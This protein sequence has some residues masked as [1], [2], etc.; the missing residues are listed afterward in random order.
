M[1]KIK[2]LVITSLATVSLVFSASIC[3]TAAQIDSLSIVDNTI[4]AQVSAEN[5]RL[6]AVEDSDGLLSDVFFKDI[7]PGSDVELPVG[8]ASV[9][10]LYLWDRESLAPISVSYVLRDGV[11]YPEGSE[12]PV[13]AYDFS[14]YSFNQDDSVMVVSAV[15]ETEI[16]GFMSGV[17]TTYSLTDNIAVLGISDN[18]ADVVPGSVVLI[19]TNKKGDCA[20]IELLASLG[21]PI[22]EKA[23][24][25]DFG[26]Y[27]PSDGSSRYKNVVNVV[28]SKSNTKLTLG[29]AGNKT[30]YC[31]ESSDVK[32]YRVGLAMM[33]DQL[34]VS[35]AEKL[36]SGK[37][38]ESPIKSTSGFNN[39]VYLRV[40]TEQSKTVSGVTY[41]GLITQC[42]VFS[43]PKE[44]NF[45]PDD[46][47]DGKYSPI[48]GLEPIV[49]ID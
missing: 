3:A 24:R 16:K 49:I 44:L 43:V 10:S 37:A 6:Y 22:D 32:C 4:Y 30:S 34:I 11:A 26:V 18:I 41:D 5:A 40:D 23:F 13:P 31:F 2:K 19:G 45:N 33:N 9:Y 28:F 7:V 35:A 27:T 20:A 25:E 38:D 47:P 1:L 42:I 12:T 17:E 14:G 21:W 39:Y 15:T 8:E 36:V 29:T 46:D 48:F